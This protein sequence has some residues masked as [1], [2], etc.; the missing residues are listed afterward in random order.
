MEA[1]LSVLSWNIHGLTRSLLEDQEFIDKLYK[2]DII[3]LY[4]SWGNSRSKFDIKGYKCYNLFRKF[5]NR[6]ARRCSGG[7][8]IYIKNCI[9]KG[10]KIVKNHHDTIIWLHLDKSFFKI[11]NDIFL[12]GVYLWV[13]NSP[14]YNFINDDLFTL[15]QND[16]Y[17]FESRGTVLITGD[18]NARVG[19][20]DRKDYIVCDSSINY[21]DDD[22]YCPDVPCDR[23]SMD[24]VC[25]PH[26][27]KL[28]DLCKANSFR[29]ANGRLG[30]DHGV[31]NYTYTGTLG[32]SVIDYLLLRDCDYSTINRFSIEPFCEWSDH[33][34]V[35]FSIVCNIVDSITNNQYVRTDIKWNADLRDNFRR[36][37]ISKLSAFNA[38]T[39][40]VNFNN[41]NDVNNCISTFTDIIKNVAEPLFCKHSVVYSKPRATSALCK[42]AEMVR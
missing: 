32:S 8:V 41:R 27:N 11:D 20:G 17:A 3:F 6:R 13:E 21:I 23:V 15:L 37:L 35:V 24:T 18:C 39:E 25:N 5:Q 7:I 12:A 2:H 14:A 28:L 4:E 29:I 40:N 9:N 38:V 16:I 33:A 42:Q 30:S 10:I 19:N 31:G 34:P 22:S 36:G 1:G 26:G